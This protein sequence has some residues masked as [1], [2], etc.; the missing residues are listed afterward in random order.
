MS[1][2]AKGAVSYDAAGNALVPDWLFDERQ[3]NMLR[4]PLSMCGGETTAAIQNFNNTFL[5][6]QR[7]GVV[8]KPYQQ[9]HVLWSRTDIIKNNLKASDKY[10]YNEVTARTLYSFKSPDG[11]FVEQT[12]QADSDIHPERKKQ[13]TVNSG[14]VRSPMMFAPL[15]RIL[16]APLVQP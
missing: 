4:D 14:M 5:P 11:N 9:M 6:Y 16:G 3:A 2:T 1:A 10:L 13:I 7:M 8:Y 15:V 12:A